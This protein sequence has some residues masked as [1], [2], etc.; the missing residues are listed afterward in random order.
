MSIQSPLSRRPFSMLNSSL[1]DQYSCRTLDSCRCDT[2]H[3]DMTM[4]RNTVN[5]A[6]EFVSAW[7][8]PSLTRLNCTKS[9]LISR[10]FDCSCGL[11]GVRGHPLSA[12]PSWPCTSTWSYSPVGVTAFAAAGEVSRLDSWAKSFW[13]LVVTLDDEWLPVDI[14]MEAFTFKHCCQKLSFDVSIALF[15]GSQAFKYECHRSVILD[16]GCPNVFLWG[17][18]LNYR[19]CS[20][21]EVC[22]CYLLTY[23][24]LDFLKC[25]LVAFVP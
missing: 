23:S 9:T 14:H 3:P 21:I 19:L 10:S 17:G 4:S 22:E 8:F 25:S 6:S 16:Q 7:I 11:A 15:C 20:R 12:S 2:G 13:A 18:H 5:T 1:Y 24:I